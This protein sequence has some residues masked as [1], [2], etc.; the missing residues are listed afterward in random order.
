VYQQVHEQIYRN[1]ADEPIPLLGGRTPRE[2]AR[3][4]AGREAVLRLLKEYESAEE[5]RARG[6]GRGVVDFGF[7]WERVGIERSAAASGADRR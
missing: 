6:E 4:A 7:L 3:T 2:S 5:R 1:W